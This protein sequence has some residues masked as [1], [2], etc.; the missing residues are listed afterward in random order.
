MILKI[1]HYTRITVI[2]RY[3]AMQIRNDRRDFLASTLFSGIEILIQKIVLVAVFFGEI[4]CYQTLYIG[5]NMKNMAKENFPN[6][7]IKTITTK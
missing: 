1:V 4:V 3:G 2:L 7:S 6:I 5:L